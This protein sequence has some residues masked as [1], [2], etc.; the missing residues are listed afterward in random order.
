[1]ENKLVSMTDKVLETYQRLCNG[2]ITEEEGLMI[3]VRYAKFLSQPLKIEMFVPVKD[4]ELLIKPET[5]HYDEE[6]LQASVM[7]VDVVNYEEA[8]D[9]VLFEGFD[10][11]GSDEE[12]IELEL[13][14]NNIWINF[15]K[16]KAEIIHFDGL[17]WQIETIQGMFEF[18]KEYGLNL[19][20]TPNAIKQIYG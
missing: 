16:E 13:K 4:H 2:E 20:L 7:G 10:V 17:E 12:C 14:D 1:M 8:M 5:S 19:T 18:L 9:K 15:L 11:I 6:E 3:P